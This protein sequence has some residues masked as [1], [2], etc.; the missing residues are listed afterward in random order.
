MVFVLTCTVEKK[1]THFTKLRIHSC[2]ADTAR[3]LG[4]FITHALW[5]VESFN[6][7]TVC[8]FDKRLQSQIL[9]SDIYYDYQICRFDK[10]L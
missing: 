9:L 10:F 1:C 4:D 6:S 7:P 8:W 2:P 3:N 5:S